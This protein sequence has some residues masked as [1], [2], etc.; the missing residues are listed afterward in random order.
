MIKKGD[1][2]VV[3]ITNLAFGGKG[4]GVI[5]N[6]EA[7]F[8]NYKVF[9]DGGFPGQ[10]VE[11]RIKKKK[12]KYAEGKLVKVLKK[13][14]LQVDTGFQE[15]PGAP[16]MSLPIEVQEKYKQAQVVELFEKF[17]KKE[18]EI[19]Q[20]VSSPETFFYRNKMEYSFGHDIES[21]EEDAEGKKIWM[22]NGFALGSKKRGQFWLV[23]NLDKPSGIFDEEFEKLLPLIRDYC[24]NTGLPVYNS[25]RNNGFFRN[26]LVRKSFF[27]NKFLIA[28]ITTSG[29]DLEMPASNFDAKKFAEF[30]EEKLENK[31]GGVFH[32][33][34]DDV[35]DTT[36]K[37]KK[38]FLLT[39]KAKIIE[40]INNLTFEISLDS[41][42]QTKIFSAAKLYD[43]ATDKAV[44]EIDGT[45]PTNIFDLFCGTGTIAQLLK[46]KAVKS[47][48]YGVDIVKSAIDDARKNAETNNVAGIK[49]FTDDVGKFL[50][51]HP[52][53]DNK[54]EVIVL[55]PPRAGIAPKT[56]KKIIELGAK[57]LVYISCN[58]ATQA[59]DTEL[60]EANNYKLDNLILVDQFPHTAHVE[61]IA[62]FMKK[63]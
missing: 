48:I 10:E 49:F 29:E 22:H 11:V 31:I 60:L 51:S 36:Q 54:M 41:F 30:L 3:E 14:E 28:I 39:G 46:K 50:T 5:K 16:W 2:V 12:K 55:D 56:L 58:P 45:A 62:V 52:E 19:E 26:L 6:A 40:K 4:I 27:E 33:I 57:R 15:I 8:V 37:Y 38:R 43:I 20:Y 61:S 53:F 7:E 47:K 18:I 42:F 32:Q 24:E 34:S 9:V 35:A 63:I 23:E 17:A 13:S 59:R 25:K 44:A 21:F 1:I